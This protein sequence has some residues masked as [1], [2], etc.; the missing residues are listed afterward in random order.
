[1]SD[2][3]SKTGEQDPNNGNRNGEGEGGEHQDPP[4]NK[5]GEGQYTKEEVDNLVKDALKDIKG[6]LDKVYEERDSL[7]TEVAS[8]KQK[9]RE[10]ELERL[11]EEGK[12]KE[13]F[14]AEI[15]DYKA[16]LE[17]L[18]KKNTELTRDNRVNNEL[19]Q[20]TFRS[21]KARQMAQFEITQNLI[22]D[23]KGEWV[24]KSGVPLEDFIKAFSED[25]SNSFLFKP[26]VSSGTGS[27]APKSGDFKP[28]KSIFDMS[29]EEIFAAARAGKLPKP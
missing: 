2:D 6:K 26:K 28:E 25:E 1:M 21:D 11:K 7:K 3:D 24:H 4:K 12:H 22:K 18:E 8:F 16:R 10:A 20:F 27:T 13:A 15:S 17:A 14:E 29:Q 19:S 9:E 5:G 23:E